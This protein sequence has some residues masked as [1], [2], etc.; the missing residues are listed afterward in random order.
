MKRLAYIIVLT[1]LVLGLAMP[2]QS[3][4]S[5]AWVPVALVGGI[6]LG[7]VIS[8]AAAETSACTYNVRY[9]VD[10]CPVPVYVYSQP[11]PVYVNFPHYRSHSPRGKIVYRH[12]RRPAP[13]P[14]HRRA[15]RR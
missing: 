10:A 2:K 15:H 6:I 4:A 8:E 13:P 12:D 14:Q 9:S 1:T 5:D 7:A 3:E 11:R